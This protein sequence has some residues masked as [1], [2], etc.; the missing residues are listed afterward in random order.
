MSAAPSIAAPADPP[1]SLRAAVASPSVVLFLA[2][3]ASQAGV[4]VLAPI[5]SAIASD[6]GVSVA[7][8]GQLRILAAPLAAVVAVVAGRALGRYSPRA[9]LGAGSVVLAF[10][11]VASAF[12]PTFLLLALA[13]IP[14]WAGIATLLAAGVA[15]TASWS[16]PAERSRVVARAFAGAPA[17]WIIGMPVIGLVASVDWRLAFL[18][19]PLPAAVLAC[20]AAAARPGDVPFAA[21]GT[22]LLGLLG[23]LPARRWALGELAA[24]SA[25]AGTLV[26][27]GALFTER[28]GASSLTTG[29]A[30]ALI[31][32][33]YLA[34]GQW[35]GRSQPERARRVMLEGSIAASALVA[36]TWA[37]TPDFAV[38]M[39]LFAVAAFVVAARMVSSTVYGFAVVGDH[40]REVGT[41]RGITTQMGYLIG[42]LVGGVAIAVGGFAL[43]AVALGGLFVVATLPHICVR[44]PCPLRAAVEPAG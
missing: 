15:A 38:T 43:L 3:F 30:L 22:G 12:A 26:F 20:L 5:L 28:Y 10:G 39:V 27:S 7:A 2:L 44:K 21:T 18:A 14:M 29:I 19:F 33:A 41:I 40:G 4:L 13:Q 16:E 17:A 42:S 37:F 9:L 23:R 36:I 24:N 8:A 6:F 31:A 34:G 1:R 32:C 25:W 11:S 35:A